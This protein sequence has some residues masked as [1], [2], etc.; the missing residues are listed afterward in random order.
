MP[1]LP[2]ALA[3]SQHQG[4]SWRTAA[5]N[6]WILWGYNMIRSLLNKHGD[7]F[8]NDICATIQ[9]HLEQNGIH[10]ATIRHRVK[11]IY[12]IYRKMYMQNKDLRR[13]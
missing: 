5:C 7:E 10:G 1:P 4:R 8:L 9:E 12:G 2:T 11:S 3:F 6:T 13:L